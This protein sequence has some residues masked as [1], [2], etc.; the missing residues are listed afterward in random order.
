VIPTKH[1]PIY[2][3]PPILVLMGLMFCI[4]IVSHLARPLSL[5]LRLMGNMFGDHT[6]VAIFT[7]IVP[8]V[9]VLVPVPVM[10]LGVFVC[11]VQTLVFC[12]LSVIYIS[13][14]IEHAEE[15]H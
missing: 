9:P 11:F 8:M 7:V 3:I 2:A 14:A 6:V 15:H 4:E 5:S 1:T 12:L 10:L 13:L